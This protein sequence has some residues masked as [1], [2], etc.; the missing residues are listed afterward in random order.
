MT[1]AVLRTTMNAA[2]CN[3]FQKRQHKVRYLFM[4]QILIS[5][6]RREGVYWGEGKIPS[7]F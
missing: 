6:T 7:I 1:P 5:V 2:F 4:S 3:K